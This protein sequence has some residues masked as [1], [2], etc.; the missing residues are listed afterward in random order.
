LQ[1]NVTSTSREGGR[2]EQHEIVPFRIDGHAYYA[3][4]HPCEYRQSASFQ[5]DES[6]AFGGMI[7][8]V[9]QFVKQYLQSRNSS[10]AASLAWRPSVLLMG[11]I[12]FR[13]A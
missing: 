2:Y 8:R 4:R 13:V 6:V 7:T 3:H 9:L 10:A 11:S 12:Y 1:L 5:T